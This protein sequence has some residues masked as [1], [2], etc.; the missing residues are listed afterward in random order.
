M[1]EKMK[2]KP[3]RVPVKPACKCENKKMVSDKRKES[4]GDKVAIIR[5]PDCGK[6]ERIS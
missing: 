4:I 2:A 6:E 3:K 1:E 5:C